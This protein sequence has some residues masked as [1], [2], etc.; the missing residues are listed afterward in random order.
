MKNKGIDTLYDVPHHPPS[1]FEKG[2]DVLPTGHGV[3]ITE[4]HQRP[5]VGRLEEQ[6]AGES[7][8]P[9]IHRPQTTQQRSH[10]PRQGAG[11][12]RG[13]VIEPLGRGDDQRLHRPQCKLTTRPQLIRHFR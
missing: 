11:M 2:T 4:I 5:G 6:V 7:T 10:R 1:G 8:T 13:Q 12:T 9:A 3:L